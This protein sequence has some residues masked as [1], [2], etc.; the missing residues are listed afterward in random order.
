MVILGIFKLLGGIVLLAPRLP[1]LKEWAYAGVFFELS[2]AAASWALHGDP[3]S[4]VIGP[5]SLIIV[6]MISWALRPPSRMLGTIAPLGTA[7]VG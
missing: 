1:R 4:E 2:G 6:A 5:I 7:R 3:A